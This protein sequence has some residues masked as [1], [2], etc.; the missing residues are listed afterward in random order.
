MQRWLGLRG[1]IEDVPLD[2]WLNKYIFPAENKQVTPA[3]VYT[4]TKAAIKEMRQNGIA[5]FCDMYFFEDQVAAAAKAAKVK[6][7]IGETIMDLPTPSAKNS[8]QSLVL[9]EDLIKKYKDDA[10]VKVSVAAHSIYTTSAQTLKKAK[11]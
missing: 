3:F 5:V 2:I 6:A 1:L 10:D 8:A 7:V 4:Q 9:T 11:N